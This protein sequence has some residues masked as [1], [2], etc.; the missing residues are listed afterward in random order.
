VRQGFPTNINTDTAGTSYVSE[1]V[2]GSYPY[3]SR[4]PASLGVLS[5]SIRGFPAVVRFAAPQTAVA[6]VPC[7]IRSAS[8]ASPIRRPGC[9]HRGA[10]PEYTMETVR[11]SSL[12]YLAVQYYLNLGFGEAI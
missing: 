5:G 4:L 2:S 12:H 1:P 9:A 3:A 10:I 8:R 11:F 7:I 6:S